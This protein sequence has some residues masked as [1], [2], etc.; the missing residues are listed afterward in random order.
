MNAPSGTGN[1]VAG[2]GEGGPA[3]SCDLW[4]PKGL[5][6]DSLG[7]IYIGE[8]NGQKIKKISISSPTIIN[9]IAGTGSSYSPAN[10]FGPPTS[11]GLSGPEQLYCSSANNKLYIADRPSWRVRL[12]D[13][14][15]ASINTFAGFGTSAGFDDGTGDRT[16]TVIG[17]VTGVWGSTNSDF[18]LATYNTNRIKFITN[19][20]IM[21]TL[22]AGPSAT[23]AAI[24]APGGDGGPLTSAQFNA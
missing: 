22:A 20:N 1:K 2:A 18:Y 3:T 10:D 17:T 14:S 16:S 11:I 8:N 13:M 4:G 23:G 6:L 12:F 9:T 5:F 21:S 19:G 7:N 24:V 15:A